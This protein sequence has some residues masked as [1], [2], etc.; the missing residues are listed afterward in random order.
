MATSSI[1]W[2]EQTWNPVTGCTRVSAGCDNCYA[3]TMT[4]RLAAMGQA[5]YQGL[6]GKGHFNGQ[7]KT[8]DDALSVPLKRRKPTVWFVNSM[9]DLFHPGVPFEFIDRVFAVMALCPQHT[10]QVLTK[11]PARMAEYL[12]AER[13]IHGDTCTSSGIIADMSSDRKERYMMGLRE[14]LSRVAPTNQGLPLPNVWLGTSVES[15]APVHRI[16]HL[17]RCPAAVRFLSCEPLLSSLALCIECLNGPYRPDTDGMHQ[18]EGGRV[19]RPCGLKGIH[20][21]IAGGESGPGARPCNIA[22]IRSLVEQCKAAGVPAFVKQIG[23]QPVEEGCEPGHVF[24]GRNPRSLHKLHDPKGGDPDE[25]PDDLR[26][27]EVPEPA[28]AG[29]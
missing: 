20:W 2:T 6:S 3:A 27:R 11:R 14:A 1:E 21:V 19:Q 9:S 25:W 4:K 24:V 10:F 15:S 29:V 18:L 26:V 8:H 7:V 16:E 17:K 28:K 22:W 12:T 5:K 23:A 13:N